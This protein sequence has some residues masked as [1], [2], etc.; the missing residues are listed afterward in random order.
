M[1]SRRVFHPFHKCEEYLPDGGM[2]R[3]TSGV[4]ESRDYAAKAERLMA[5][6]DAFEAAM[7]RALTEWPRSCE[8]ALT[9]EQNN[10]RAWLGHAGCYLATGSPEECT[11][12]GWHAL[13][14]AEQRAANAAA[15]RVILKWRTGY[16]AAAQA[17]LFEFGDDHA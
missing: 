17:S 1:A 14:D 12:L 8:M 3:I 15:D 7:T 11:R 16:F 6:P 10:Q 2:W 5:D 4:K 13:D 9:G